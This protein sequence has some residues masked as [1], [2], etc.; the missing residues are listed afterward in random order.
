MILP[1]NSWKTGEA[2]SM[3][4]IFFNC[5]AFN[6]DLSKWDVS[7]VT[8]MNYAFYNAKSFN[9]NLSSWEINKRQFRC[10]FIFYGSGFTQF[11][12][13][14]FKFRMKIMEMYIVY[15]GAALVF[16]LPIGLV[17]LAI[18]DRSIIISFLSFFVLLLIFWLFW[19]VILHT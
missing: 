17:Y 5:K 6:Q 1:L 7:G 3:K 11:G 14:S 13:L 16:A 8:G 18:V 9:Q 4:G 19:K 15:I 10:L 12:S 2:T